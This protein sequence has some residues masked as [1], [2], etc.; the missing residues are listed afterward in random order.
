MKNVFQPGQCTPFAV[1]LARLFGA[2]QAHECLAASFAPVEA[3]QDE[4]VGVEIDVALEFGFKVGLGTE[5]STEA[6]DQGSKG[7]HDRSSWGE[8]KTVEG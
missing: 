4:S 3:S 2:T 5:E 6:L 8:G 7:S 1:R